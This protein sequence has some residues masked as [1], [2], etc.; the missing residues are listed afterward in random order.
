MPH[1]HKKRGGGL[2]ITMIYHFVLGVMLCCVM[3]NAYE[4]NFQFLL[5]WILTIMNTLSVGYLNQKLK[6]EQPK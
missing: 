6:D 1:E 5:L 4:H 2:R 3:W